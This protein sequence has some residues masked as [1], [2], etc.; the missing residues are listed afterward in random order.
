MMV[1]PRHRYN[2]SGFQGITHILQTKSHGPHLSPKGTTT[3]TSAT[4]TGH[5]SQ[6]QITMK[7]KQIVMT[8][9]RIQIMI[10]QV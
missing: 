2:S 9:H 10:P 5:T 4:Q 7:I 8:I 1:K 3:M 6:T